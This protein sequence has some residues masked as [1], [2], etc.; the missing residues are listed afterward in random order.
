VDSIGYWKK[1]REEVNIIVRTSG[2][3]AIDFEE[4]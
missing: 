4:T 1:R 2:K 3:R